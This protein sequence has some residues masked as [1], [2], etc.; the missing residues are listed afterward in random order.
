MASILAFM[1][2]SGHTK[3]IPRLTGW[4]CMGAFLK[5]M[6][7]S[8][9]TGATGPELEQRRRLRLALAV[10]VVAL[11][12]VIIRDLHDL[13]PPVTVNPDAPTVAG[14]SLTA[15]PSTP[16]AELNQAPAT[17][18][19]SI[20]SSRSKHNRLKRPVVNV[21]QL[22]TSNE[23][24]AGP[25]IVATDRAV[26]PPLQVEVVAGGQHQ[27]AAPAP[28]SNSVRVNMPPGEAEADKTPA[29]EAQITPGSSHTS[30]AA[31][32]SLSQN[33][34]ER[35]EH[36]VAPAYPLLAKQMK[37]QGAVVLQALI[38]KGGR[39]QNLRVVSGP[40]ILAAAAQ[41][42]V[43]QW[44]FKPYYLNGEAVETEARVSVNFTIST[45]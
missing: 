35:V 32:V 36:S 40:A 29:A 9:G 39:I 22:G 25:T 2:I 23:L 24:S 1:E 28:A 16:Q 6:Q 26:L 34:S 43:K 18:P 17:P 42:A 41:E 12:V 21:A 38:D 14:T 8:L 33:A 10:L 5:W 15:P 13:R 45:F 11:F 44:R 19:A 27:A 31:K 3:T 7:S 4:V 20:K 37:V 30:N